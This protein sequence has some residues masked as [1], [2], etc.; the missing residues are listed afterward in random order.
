MLMF[1]APDAR[2]NERA[3]LLPLRIQVSERCQRRITLYDC[4]ECSATDL[5][6]C[7]FEMMRAVARATGAQ[8]VMSARGE[9]P[10]RYVIRV[11]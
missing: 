7:R 11:C 2:E 5:Q 4:R 8:Y 3:R 1:D 9:D 6:A 10:L